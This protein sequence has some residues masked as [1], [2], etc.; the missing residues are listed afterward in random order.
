MSQQVRSHQTNKPLNDNKQNKRLRPQYACFRPHLQLSTKKSFYFDT[1]YKYL[2]HFVFGV[3]DFD[4]LFENAGLQNNAAAF[5]I[6]CENADMAAEGARKWCLISW[7]PD[8]C[9]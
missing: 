1:L 8:L 6:F 2:C 3:Q 5:V 4:N 7:V 9:R